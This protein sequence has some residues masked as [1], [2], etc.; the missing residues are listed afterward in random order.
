MKTLIFMTLIWTSILTADENI[1]VINPKLIQGQYSFTGT[2]TTEMGQYKFVH[3][4]HGKTSPNTFECN[5][6]QDMGHMKMTGFVKTDGDLGTM[7]LQNMKEQK[8]NAELAIASATGVS[9][10]S[11]YLIYALW[12]GNKSDIFPNKNIKITQNKGLTIITGTHRER[13][14]TVTMKKDDIISIESLFDPIKNKIK[15]KKELTDDQIKK[16]L[17]ATNK[18]VTPKAIA[19]MNEMLGKANKSLSQLKDKIK[20]KTVFTIK[21]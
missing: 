17:K 1:P 4:F 21:Y 2:V 9:G 6:E 3:E 13:T 10:G 8:S 20:T 16:V 18:E 7:K 15:N 5:W 12:K 19:D 11:A 14:L